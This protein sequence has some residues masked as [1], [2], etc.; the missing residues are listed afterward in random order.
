MAASSNRRAFAQVLPLLIVV[1][2]FAVRCYDLDRNPPGF[3]RDEAD[4]AVTAKSL[5][6]NGRDLEG[7]RLPYFVRSLNVYTSGAYQYA[8]IPFI[9]L[10]GMG[11]WVIRL[12]AALAGAATV[13]VA[14]LLG[15]EA[16]GR[17]T[18]RV[19]A[20]LLAISPW[21]VC[22]S[23]W[24]N[25]GIFLPLCLSLAVYCLLRG[26]RST[27]ASGESATPPAGGNCRP[28][29]IS[30]I[31]LSLALYTYAPAKVLVPLFVVAMAAIYRREFFARSAERRWPCCYP[32]FGTLLLLSLP[33]VWFTLFEAERSGLRYDR[34][35]IFSQA[36]SPAE[37][38]LLFFQGY[39][40]HFSPSFLLR[41]G[42]ANLRHSVPGVGQLL[43]PEAIAALLGLYFV[44]RRR[45]REDLLLLAWV[46]LGPL[47]AAL[48]RE[49]LPHALRSLGALPAMQLL[50]AVGI[51][52][53]LDFLHRWEKNRGACSFS[54]WKVGIVAWVAGLILFGG[55]FLATLYWVYPVVSAPWWEYGYAEAV[56]YLEHHRGDYEETV[57]TG[58]IE[59]PQVQIL[60]H[61]GRDPAEYQRTGRISGYRFLPLGRPYVEDYQRSS[62]KSLYLLTPFE[63][64][65]V[66][67]PALRWIKHPDGSPAWVVVEHPAAPQ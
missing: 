49:G 43:W 56:T 64:D 6:L 61:T 48:T 62:R 36:T 22:L 24:A 50:G 58:L 38:V 15:K 11:E 19:A 21:H 34:I 66:P 44:L 2:A 3:F 31:F 55:S 63:H 33:M 52:Q 16:Y 35:S 30:A 29:V 67:R 18:G 13:A 28:F 41:T 7:R 27:Q 60:Y 8:L 26:R 14:Y 65:R 53:V 32:Y 39:L 12:P 10:L 59:Y 23:R 47:P 4:K 9:L 54:P 37:L 57:I 5:L 1:F 20:A 42:D 25:Q 46:A 45:S 40:S 17:S 51:V